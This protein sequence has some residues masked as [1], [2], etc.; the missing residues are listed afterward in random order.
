MLP[1]P[2]LAAFVYM[3][4]EDEAEFRDAC[5]NDRQI[6]FMAIGAAVAPIKQVSAVRRACNLYDDNLIK[7]YVRHDIPGTIFWAIPKE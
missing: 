4:E 7:G 3:S 1:S 5:G 2:I 6:M